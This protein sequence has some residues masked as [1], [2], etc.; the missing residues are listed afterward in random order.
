MTTSGEERGAYA[1]NIC[2]INPI[3]SPLKYELFKD[4]LS[5]KINT[6]FPIGRMLYLEVNDT[7]EK[8]ETFRAKK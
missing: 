2:F 3:F 5:V 8:N 1:R 7:R 4:L 6:N